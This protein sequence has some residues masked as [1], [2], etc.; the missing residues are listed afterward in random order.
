MKSCFLK[1]IG[2]S[3]SRPGYGFSP[4]TKG[5]SL[6][7]ITIGRFGNSVF[8]LGIPPIWSECP[9]VKITPETLSLS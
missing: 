2:S 5:I 9:C 4:E 1:V 3:F 8:N 7:S 6:L